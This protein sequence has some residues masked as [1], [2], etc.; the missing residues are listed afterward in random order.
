MTEDIP[1][2]IVVIFVLA[3]M[4]FVYMISNGVYHTPSYEV[5]KKT[6]YPYLAQYVDVRADG[7]DKCL[8]DT[9]RIYKEIQK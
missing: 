3:I 7:S 5:C 9:T 1:K 2:P 6:C 8:C 4:F